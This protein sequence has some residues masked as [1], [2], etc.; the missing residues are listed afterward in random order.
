MKECIGELHRVNDSEIIR[1]GARTIKWLHLCLLYLFLL[2]GA[3]KHSQADSSA[4][5]QLEASSSQPWVLED[6]PIPG[7]RISLDCSSSRMCF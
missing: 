1:A 7:P 3:R 4:C 2:V 5:P 6:L